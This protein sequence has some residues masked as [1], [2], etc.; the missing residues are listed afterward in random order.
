MAKIL[1]EDLRFHSYHGVHDFEARD[2]GTFVV[3]VT[4]ELDLD[5]AGESDNLGDTLDYESAYKIVEEEMS[6]RSKLIENVAYRIKNRL[7]NQWPALDEAVVKIWKLDPPIE[8]DIAATS[9][10]L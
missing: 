10:I 8:G 4:L 5:K 6:R 9:V 3:N 7:L 2:G 1:L